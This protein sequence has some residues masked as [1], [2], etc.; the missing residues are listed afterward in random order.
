MKILAIGA[1]PDDIEIFMYGLL[2]IFKDRGDQIFTIIATDGGKGGADKKE[3]LI[4]KRMQESNLAL[5]NLSTPIFLGI[6]DG[7]L[8]D[9]PHHKK[10]IKK[11]IFE[12][13]P[14]LV[15]THSENDYHA[16][17]R[18]LSLLS[19]SAVSH[20]IPILFCDTLMGIKFQPNYY[21]D[22]TNYF[23]VK[24]N[25]ILCHGSQHPKRFVDLSELMNTYRAAQCNSPKGSYAEAYNFNPS[26]PFSDLRD[27]LPLS[28]KL[29][30]FHIENQRGFL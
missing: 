29:R 25:A 21:I 8:G 26:F 4:K 16:D 6:P 13:M 24:K 27:I 7:E 5:K 12:V 3:I 15:I 28:P 20:Y 23:E 9:D 2:S 18:A 10:I 14:D 22:I 17:H 11:K 30:P 19:S 1:H